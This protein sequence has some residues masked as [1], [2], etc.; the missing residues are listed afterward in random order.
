MHL[1]CSVLLS[2]NDGSSRSKSE[3][4]KFAAD[5]SCNPFEVRRRHGRLSSSLS[6]RCS[7]SP[8]ESADA[9]T[10]MAAS[11]KLSIDEPA[12]PLEYRDVHDLAVPDVDDEAGRRVD[13]AFVQVAHMDDA[14]RN[15]VAEVVQV[16]VPLHPLAIRATR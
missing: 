3:V 10:S 7:S 1:V 5:P 9:A 11:D 16:R 14:L 2:L 12:V 8:A 4:I 15:Q 13:A 6:C